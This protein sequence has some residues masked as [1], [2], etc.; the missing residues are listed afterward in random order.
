MSHFDLTSNIYTNQTPEQKINT[1]AQHVLKNIKLIIDNVEYSLNEIEFYCYNTNHKDSYTH[2]DKDQLT[3]QEWYFH[4]Y[5]NGT[6]KNGTYKGLDI[7]FGDIKS[8][9]YGGILIRTIE[10]LSN[11]STII[12]PCNVVNHIINETGYNT[13]DELVESLENNN[14]FNTKNKFHLK[15]SNNYDNRQ[16]FDG[17][18]VGL[19]LKYPEYLI[20]NYRFLKNPNDIPKYKDTIVST[21]YSKGHSINDIIKMT[22]ISKKT[23][24]KSISDFDDG[25][26]LSDVDVNKTKKINVLYGYYYNKFN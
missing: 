1:L 10:K 7:T 8:K 21:L 11:H 24:E 26:G 19:S 15:I 13:I 6:F 17:P 25:K 20:K 9:S 2:K 22:K 16:I 12:G 23:V 5:K 14:V 18:R 3:N 4:K